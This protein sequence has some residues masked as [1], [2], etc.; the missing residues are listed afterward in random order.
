MIFEEAFLFTSFGWPL[1]LL[2][3]DDHIL[4]RT[5]NAGWRN[6]FFLTIQHSVPNSICTILTKNTSQNIL[7]VSKSQKQI[8]KSGILQKNERNSLRIV[9]WVS[10]VHFF[11][12]IKDII[13][14]LLIFNGVTK[15]YLKIRIS[16]QKGFQPIMLECS[17]RGITTSSTTIT[18]L[19][20]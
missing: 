17:A 16:F 11:G 10:S 8:M 13:I 15:N 18:T 3:K 4:A 6:S 9:S 2:Q 12:R 5:L 20:S 7:K 14:I 19:A 1:I